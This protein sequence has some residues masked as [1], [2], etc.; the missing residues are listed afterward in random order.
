MSEEK[1][2]PW[3][4][5]DHK[6]FIELDVELKLE[7]PPISSTNSPPQSFLGSR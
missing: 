7:T 1:L 2:G 5:K 6:S 3:L 4:S